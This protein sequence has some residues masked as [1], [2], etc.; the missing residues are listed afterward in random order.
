MITIVG[1]KSCDTCRKAV[2]SLQAAGKAVGLRDVRE[3]PPTSEEMSA[4]HG[5]FGE[6][7]VNTRSTTW[8]GLSEAE[9]DE[10]P[11]S[12]LLAHPALMKRPLVLPENG[13]PLLGWTRETR[14]E[15]GV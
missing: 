4:W 8:R 5:R 6:S 15:L 12:L 10:P 3:T 1:L 9:R 13:A 2:K 11:V 7:L 14:A